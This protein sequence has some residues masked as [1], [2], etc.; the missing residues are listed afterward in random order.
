M[1]MALHHLV[2]ITLTTCPLLPLSVTVLTSQW[3]HDDLL[4]LPRSPHHPGFTTQHPRIMVD[5]LGKATLGTEDERGRNQDCWS[6]SP[7]GPM[8]KDQS[9][10]QEPLVVVVPRCVSAVCLVA[11]G[12]LVYAAVAKGEFKF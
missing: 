8:A 4:G 12:E 1:A 2:S 11:A 3:P 10:C 5:L 9:D 7:S 6:Y